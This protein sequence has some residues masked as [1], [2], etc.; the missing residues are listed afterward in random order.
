MKIFI[1]GPMSDLP[2]NNIPRFDNTAANLRRLGHTVVNPAEFVP[3]SVSKDSYDR[4]GHHPPEIYR[5]LMKQCVIALLDCTHIHF[6]PGS[7][8]SRGSTF[9]T[10]IADFFDI[11][12]LDGTDLLGHSPGTTT[13]GS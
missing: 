12:E 2:R 9:E 4:Y 7:G 10:A 1:S 13:E 11:Q 3:T 8:A 5:D 6:L